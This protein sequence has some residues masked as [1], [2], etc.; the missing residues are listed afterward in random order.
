[1]ILT[2]SFNGKLFILLWLSPIKLFIYG[3]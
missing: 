3:R 2:R 1:M